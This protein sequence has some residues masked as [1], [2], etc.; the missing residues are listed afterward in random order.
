MDD[1]DQLSEVECQRRAQQE[2]KPRTTHDFTF[3]FQVD[4]TWQQGTFTGTLMDCGD[5][6]YEAAGQHGIELT[7]T[8][9]ARGHLDENGKP[10]IHPK[11]D[12]TAEAELRKVMGLEEPAPASTTKRQTR[13]R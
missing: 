7:K 9:Y 13:R 5:V 12:S 8:R 3:V 6:M 11:T 4:G 10:V 1:L 2:E